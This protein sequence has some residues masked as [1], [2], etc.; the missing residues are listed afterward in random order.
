MDFR[1]INNEKRQ[2]SVLTAGGQEVSPGYFVG[3]QDRVVCRNP[4]PAVSH[5]C[6]F[7]CDGEVP[8]VQHQLVMRPR[9]EML[10]DVE[11]P[12]NSYR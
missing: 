1:G 5:L 2:N 7:N 3:S 6:H 10:T 12:K 4:P 8:E 11:E 9:G